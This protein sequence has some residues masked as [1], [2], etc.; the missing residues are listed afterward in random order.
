MAWDGQN[1]RSWHRWP[2]TL[3]A[4]LEV[5]AEKVQAE[6]RDI[7]RGGVLL[8]VSVPLT[9]GQEVRLARPQLLAATPMQVARREVQPDGTVG[10][11]LRF[12]GGAPV[13]GTPGGV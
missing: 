6:I 8:V 12:I 4:Q 7:S 10:F 5:G 11:G 2:V 9:V 1:R 13:P 3:N